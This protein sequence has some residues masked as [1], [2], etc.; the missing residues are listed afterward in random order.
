M[1]HSINHSAWDGRVV[2][3]NA[4]RSSSLEMSRTIPVLGH[5]VKLT[6][7]LFFVFLSHSTFSLKLFSPF[8]IDYSRQ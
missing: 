5:D 3:V 8:V 2:T 7:F 6:P 1:S 4:V